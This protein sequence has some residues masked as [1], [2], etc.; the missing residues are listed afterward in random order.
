MRLIILGGSGLIGSSL[1]Q[2]FGNDSDFNV[3]STTSKESLLANFNKKVSCT[4]FVDAFNIQSINQLCL[5]IRP[6][7]VINCIGITKHKM[8]D[9]NISAAIE[10]NALFP[11]KLAEICDVSN[12][13]LIHISTDCVFSGNKGNYLEDDKTDA[14]DIYGKSKA[15][16]ELI[17]AH[18]ALVIRT[19]TIGHELKTNYGLLNWFLSQDTHCSGYRKAIF[20]GLPATF[21]AQVIRD[22]ILNGK[23]KGLYHISGNPI[24]KF[25][26]LKIIAE[27]Y[28]KNIIIEPD[29]SVVINRSLNSTK[30]TN[31]TGFKAPDWKTL[32]YSMY[33]FNNLKESSHV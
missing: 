7:V 32:I 26:L 13:R 11:H 1:T 18:D 21:L 5:N 9:N 30:F 23:L 25:E 28:K 29:D 20:S 2:F 4:S 6:D 19:S 14:D 24:S 10:L 12:S 22:Y 15:L 33:E 17:I 31:A 3:T 8:T 16:G 27:V